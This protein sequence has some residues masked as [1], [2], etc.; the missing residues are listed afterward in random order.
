MKIKLPHKFTPRP[1]QKEFYDTVF[2]Y[3]TGK[4]VMKK[5]R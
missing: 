5:K 2:D 4:P 1:Y 3:S